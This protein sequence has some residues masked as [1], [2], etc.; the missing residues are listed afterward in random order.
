MPRK[1]QPAELISILI[2][3]DHKIVREGLRSLLQ[4]VEDFLVV[5][6]AMDGEQAVEQAVVLHPNVV[7]MD[8]VMP[9]KNGIDATREILKHLPGTSIL[10]LTSFVEDEQI[11]QSIKAGALGYLLKDS[12]TDEL[13]EAIR[14][15]R[16]GES[17]LDPQ[18]ARKL[19]LRIDETRRFQDFSEALTSREVGV[20]RCLAQGMTNKQIGGELFVSE[21]TVR[22]HV[23]NILRKLS[24]ENRAQII[25]YAIREKIIQSG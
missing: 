3:D 23:S 12:S 22:F 14:C 11:F 13:I 24:L 4:F 15:V 6:E 7:L 25:L 20:I 5:G 21:A 19:V 16:R 17:S 10:V 8:L 2:V 18:V 9:K 1:P